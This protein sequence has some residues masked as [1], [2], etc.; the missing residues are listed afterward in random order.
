MIFLR[1]LASVC[2]RIRG[3]TRLLPEAVAML[4]EQ[5]EKLLTP[6]R[7]SE[8]SAAGSRCFV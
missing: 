6:F 2:S 8:R 7:L 3:S 5:G 4:Q 1:R